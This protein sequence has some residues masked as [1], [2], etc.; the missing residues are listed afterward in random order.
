M[1]QSTSAYLGSFPSISRLFWKAEVGR[2]CKV[3]RPRGVGLV[4]VA[5]MGARASVRLFLLLGAG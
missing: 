2:K 1:F 5:M 3:P 4:R